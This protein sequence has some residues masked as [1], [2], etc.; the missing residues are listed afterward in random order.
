MFH[1]KVIDYLDSWS[2]RPD[3][4]PLIIRGA[5]QVGKT[6]AVKMFADAI[7]GFIYLDMNAPGVR[8]IFEKNLSIEDLF[9]AIRLTRGVDAPIDQS[10]LFIDE[11]QACPAA[12]KYLRYFL[13]KIPSLKVIASGSLLDITLHEN[14]MEFPVG[15]VEHYFMYPVTFEE[16]LGAIN[17]TDL[18]EVMNSVPLPEYALPAIQEHFNRYVLMGGMPEIIAS[19][20]EFSDI[21]TPGRIFSALIVSF[22]DD[23]PKYARNRT[24]SGVLR[25][26]IEAAPVETGNRIKFAGFGGSS[27]RSREVGEALRTL[28]RA[29]LLYLVYPTTEVQLPARINM[30]KSPRLQFLDIGLMN[31]SVGIQDTLFG[32]KDLNA[33][34]RGAVAEQYI[35]QELLAM[36]SI[37]RPFIRFWTREKHNSSAEVDFVIKHE[38][39]L[40]PIEVKSG[41][42]GTLRSLRQFMQICPHEY[43][44]RF[45]SGSVRIDDVNTPS[46]KVFKLMSLPHFLVG[47][48]H[49]YL[50][51]MLKEN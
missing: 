7:P 34:H 43:A 28:Q 27:Y 25:H 20:I 49:E 26:C 47:R 23:I 31:Y 32:I 2:S 45:Y 3:R 5:R 37:S 12:F 24:M 1:R 21:V 18:P 38:N 6:T 41:K 35:G 4:K 19:S 8:N 22:E 29:M 16:Y 14:R 11:I 48:I 36:Q 17:R 40:I 42:T 33:V 44:V 50:D 51:W 46:G 10:L 30:R 15:R 13:E 9:S 39:L